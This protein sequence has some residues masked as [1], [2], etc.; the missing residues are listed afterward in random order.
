MNLKNQLTLLRL[1][2]VGAIVALAAMAVCLFSCA[3]PAADM[4]PRTER[5]YDFTVI[6]ERAGA[7]GFTATVTWT[8]TGDPT[9]ADPVDGG[10]SYSSAAY[11]HEGDLFTINVQCSEPVRLI[12]FGRTNY[13]VTLHPGITYTFDY[14]LKQI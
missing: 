8:V 9:Y 13:G 4:R 5:K 7:R 6:P 11:M 3:E 14:N 1:V 10:L 2:Q 12:F